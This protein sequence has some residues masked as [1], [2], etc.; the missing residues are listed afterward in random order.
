M[1]LAYQEYVK[2]LNYDP[3]QWPPD[4]SLAELHSRVSE[5][6]PINPAGVKCPCCNF[7][8]KKNFDGWI[9]RDINEDCRGYGT[10]IPAFFGLLM[11]YT[12]AIFIVICLNTV[13]PLWAVYYTCED[14][15]QAQAGAQSC[16]Q[17]GL[18]YYID[19]NT[20]FDVLTANG[21]ENVV[22]VIIGLC[23]I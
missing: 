1:E 11:Y 3:Y 20:E 9:M 8:S 22:R 13:Y 15:I 10:A 6:G 21:D 19:L 23:R 2:R 14:L 7:Q 4:M 5:Q 17:F 18:F 16:L 12:I